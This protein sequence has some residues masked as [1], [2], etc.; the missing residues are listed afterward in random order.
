[1]KLQI[2]IQ[3]SCFQTRRDQGIF[4]FSVNI[5]PTV[6]I[7]AMDSDNKG[8]Y[9]QLRGLVSNKQCLRVQSISR[10]HLKVDIESL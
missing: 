9:S 10:M 1:M 7:V 3:T 8:M 4:L 6:D 2:S 5:N